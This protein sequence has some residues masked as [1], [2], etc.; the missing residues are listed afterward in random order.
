MLRRLPPESSDS[1]TDARRITLHW[2]EQAIT[3][4][5]SD[6]VAAALL[7]AGVRISRKS[8]VSGEARLPFCMMGSCFECL[9][10][11]DGKV[12]QSC[13]TVVTD[14][15]QLKMPEQS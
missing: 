6:T 15:M 1:A 13:M 10:E 14:G 9:I 8:S 7:L 3:A 12:V 11:I 2:Y 4:Q 5:S